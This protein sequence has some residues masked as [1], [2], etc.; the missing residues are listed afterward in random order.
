MS[1]CKLKT[2]NSVR[3][4]T[5]RVV[6]NIHLAPSPKW[7][8]HCLAS[9]GIRPINNVVDITNYVMEEYGQPM[10]AYDLDKIAG[11]QII[12]KRAED[13]EKFTTLDGKEYTLDHDILMINDAEKR[14]V[15]PES[16]AVRIP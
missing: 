14:L 4:Y 13:G 2:P 6:K 3:A 11:H 16:W 12:V 5:A 8:Q 1:A 7:M 15:S 9:N 10:H